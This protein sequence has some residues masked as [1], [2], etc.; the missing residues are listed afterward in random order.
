M[1]L[2]KRKLEELK[3]HPDNFRKHPQR[4]IEEMAKSVKQFGIVRPI[5]ID[6]N[7]TIL[8]GHG[9]YET[10]KYLGYESADC[11]VVK[12]LNEKQKKKLLLADN[13]VYSLGYDDTDIIDNILSNLDGDFD[14]PGYD[15][16]VL[17]ELYSASSIEEQKVDE[18]LKEI[19]QDYNVPKLEKRDIKESDKQYVEVIQEQKDEDNQRKYIL[20]PHCKMRIYLDD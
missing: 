5:V 16:N 8:C 20:C 12:G 13:K 11:Y 15:S 2:E 4:Q 18:Q 7:N 19:E 1:Q 14:I 3:K 9:L 6:E 10:L 17:E